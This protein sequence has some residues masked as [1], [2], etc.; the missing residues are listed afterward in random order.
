MGNQHL[1]P[2]HTVKGDR[3][4]SNPA[5]LPLETTFTKLQAVLGNRMGGDRF[6]TACAQHQRAGNK[7]ASHPLD[8]LLA[9]IGAA[10]PNPTKPLFR[11]LS[12]ELQVSH[13]PLGTRVQTKMA[14]GKP[15]DQYEQEA[16]R[17]AAKVVNQIHTPLLHASVQD[18]A[19][20]RQNL[21]GEVRTAS[22]V[23]RHPN[24]GGIVATTD[25]ETAIHQ[26]QGIGQPLQESIRTPMEQA[27]G[28][29]F[30]DV[31][32][33]TD[34][35]S[36]QLNQS[37]QAN[38]FTT[39]Q[40]IFFRQG[41]YNPESQSGQ[42]LIAHEL[43]HVVQQT[44]GHSHPSTATGV[45]QRAPTGLAQEK[46]SSG[47]AAVVKQI[48]D[49][50]IFLRLNTPQKRGEAFV[51]AANAQLAK[52][53]VPPM[54]MDLGGGIGTVLTGG[55]AE[56]DAA[57]H[58]LLWEIHM[59]P[60]DLED[61][62]SSLGGPESVESIRERVV[63]IAERVYHE[64]RHAEQYFRSARLLAGQKKKSGEIATEL[65]IYLPV[66]TEALKHPLTKGLLSS[67]ITKR[68]FSE[69]E[70]WLQSIKDSGAIGG[71]VGTKKDEW[72][73]ARNLFIQWVNYEKDNPH[74]LT[75]K[76]G[77]KKAAEYYERMTGEFE[78]LY[79]KYQNIVVEQDAWAIGGEISTKLGFLP[80]K[81]DETFEVLAMAR[82][83]LKPYA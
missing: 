25:L 3:Q 10:R 75:A 71:A 39:G 32:I 51:N 65:S 79:Q 29:T 31:R 30:N 67:N 45:V 34:A 64:A 13:G 22:L 37:I 74:E 15:N 6:K 14:I 49:D 35:Q 59:S 42:T 56:G 52:E 77:L 33:H 8:T 36:D 53:N 54:G 58:A 55:Q 24:A 1:T 9:S 48:A 38:A 27:F 4:S 46:S 41:T 43:T 20:Q 70:A 7:D 69:A 78:D 82:Q 47:F 2:P 72:L 19:I 81:T 17:I 63:R 57:F 23:Q 40:D 44:G 62:K 66:V 11:G 18:E 76:E 12:H 5:S 83:E 50:W 60:S 68:E 28:T 16:D 80:N 61:K 73:E 26:A 21:A